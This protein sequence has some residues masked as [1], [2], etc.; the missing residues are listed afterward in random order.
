[1]S[2]SLLNVAGVAQPDA[3]SNA[4]PG[5]ARGRAALALAG[6]D[7]ATIARIR[8]GDA[9]VFEELM[10][11][12]GPG[13]C[14][15]ATRLTGSG[16]AAE[17]IVQDVFVAV[18]IN[19]ERMAVHDSVRTYLYRAVRNR[20]VSAHR[21][22]SLARRAF[23]S[24][25]AERASEPYGQLTA[26]EASVER[27]QLAAAVWRAIDGLPARVRQAFILVREHELTYAEAAA[28]MGVTPKA[29]D[30]SLTRAAKALRESLRTVWP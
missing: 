16:A 24:L 20:A 13:L 15:F 11:D 25:T 4:A 28:V 17:E 30:V 23:E 22:R 19:R 27:S 26:S 1:M 6:D 29:I 2:A 12:L 10:R 5:G 14:A 3:G 7:H 18:W 21:R 9:R 8:A